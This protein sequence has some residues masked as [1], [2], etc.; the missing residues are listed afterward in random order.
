MPITPH[1]ADVRSRGKQ[2]TSN[3]LIFTPDQCFR[4]GHLAEKAWAF[5]LNLAAALLIFLVGKWA[6]KRIVAVMRAAMTRAQ[7]DATLISFC[8]MLP[9]SAY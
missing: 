3:N 6:A 8:V 2:W 9:I 7:V 1:G 5:G 4:L